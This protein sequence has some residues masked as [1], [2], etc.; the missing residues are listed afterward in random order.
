MCVLENRRVA[1]LR[2]VWIEGFGEGRGSV[3]KAC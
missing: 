3:L 2:F 1:M